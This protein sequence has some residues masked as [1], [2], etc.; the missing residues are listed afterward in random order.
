MVLGRNA[1][2]EENGVSLEVV[3][4]WSIDGPARNPDEPWDRV[5]VVREITIATQKQGGGFCDYFPGFNSRLS[6]LANDAPTESKSF[7]SRIIKDQIDFS[8]VR[9]WINICDEHHKDQC[10][11]VHREL[12]PLKFTDVM[13]EIPSFHVVDVIDNCVTVAP[14]SCHYAALSYVWGRIDPQ[15]ILKS[16]KSNIAQLEKQRLPPA[17][18]TP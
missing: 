12:D 7:F 15:A 2:D 4:Y 16:Y 8:M 11:G 3:F 13:D 9:N 5:P 14:R 1:P 17:I 10:A 6:I 18:R